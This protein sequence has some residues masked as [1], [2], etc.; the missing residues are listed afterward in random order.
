M[1]DLLNSNGPMRLKKCRRG[2]MLYSTNDVTI[3]QLFDLYGEFSEGEVTLLEKLVRPGDTVIEVGANIGALTVPLAQFVGPNGSIVAFEP[4][5][6]LFQNLCANLALNGHT[7]VRAQNMAVG[8]DNGS[9]VLPKID[10]AQPGIFGGHSIEGVTNGEA[11]TLIALD[12]FVNTSKCRLMKIDVEGMEED[13][14]RSASGLI[15][16][17]QPFLYVENDRPE[18]SESLISTIQ[19]FG[20]T[21]YWHLPPLCRVDN[22]FGQKL[23]LFPNT[24]SMNMLC[25][26]PAASVIGME[27]MRICSPQDWWEDFIGR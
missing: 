1:Q 21:L 23:T 20:Y 6:V 16:R 27:N 25:V 17:L 24:L 11:V 2:H 10:F 4:Q 26:P 7:V 14:I 12:K 3:G 19:G 15:T 5:H 8:M 9:V 13:V 18:K 22:Y